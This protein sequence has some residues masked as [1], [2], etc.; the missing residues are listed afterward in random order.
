MAISTL[1]ADDAACY[2]ANLQSAD[3]GSLGTFGRAASCRGWESADVRVSHAA[4]W[5]LPTRIVPVV[6]SASMGGLLHWLPHRPIL[7][8]AGEEMRRRFA[9]VPCGR[10]VSGLRSAGRAGRE[11]STH[12]PERCIAGRQR[13]VSQRFS[14]SLNKR[15]SG[16]SAGDRGGDRLVLGC[17]PARERAVTSARAGVSSHKVRPRPQVTRRFGRPPALSETISRLSS[18]HLQVLSF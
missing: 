8:V 7:H 6:P 11:K 2:L 4:C 14:V 17:T 1:I 18:A 5:R 9:D 15:S 13:R 3:T 10:W 12:L 16:A